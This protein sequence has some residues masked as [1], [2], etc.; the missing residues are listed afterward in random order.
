[1]RVKVGI[2]LAAA[3]LT[4]GVLA[5]ASAGA[6]TAAS[7]GVGVAAGTVTNAS[8]AAMA[9]VLVDLYAWPSDSVLKAMKPGQTVAT[10]LLATATTNSAGGYSL[11]V[12]ATELKAAAVESGFANL[13]IYSASGIWFLS[14]QTD[15]LPADPPGA[16]TVNLADST[17]SYACGYEANGQP[18]DFTGFKLLKHTAPASAVV[19]QGYIVR[20]KATAGD[21]VS[22]DYTQASS[23]TQST[24]LG[25][26]LSGYGVSAGYESDGANTSTARRSEGFP[27]A[28][29]YALFQTLFSTAQFRG[30]CLSPQPNTP[31]PR[32]QQHGYC[33]K[34]I[35]EPKTGYKVYVHMCLWL[36]KST[37][38]F[39]GATT[40]YP[41][42]A[43]A[44][45]AQYCAPQE[46]GT[47]FD[48]DYGA[49]VSWAHG[50]QLGTALNIKGLNLTASFGSTAQ[51][52]Y[53][54]NAL[55]DYGFAQKGYL[56]GLNAPISSASVL[57]ARANKQ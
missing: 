24:S 26:G 28:F 4:L 29:G 10:T 27:R 23:H 39:G 45:P 30:E 47:H 48:A 13:E 35:I 18:Y 34:V 5:P 14:Y 31:V 49:A 44:T 56:C 46:R 55:L 20:G 17:S 22:F 12:P 53:D 2:T 40:T 6:S 15:S 16:V 19:G 7:S 25:V 57:V 9:D 3:A 54:A 38:W 51:T 21:W 1:M 8:G 41:K 50:Y 43:W 36:V 42:S 11:Q 32:K 33:P 52:G 37:G